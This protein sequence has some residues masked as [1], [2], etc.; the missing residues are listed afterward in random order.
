MFRSIMAQ[1]LPLTSAMLFHIW[2]SIFDEC[3][4]RLMHT[5]LEV[6]KNNIQYLDFVF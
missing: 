3:E 2:Y 4:V 5:A 6:H 1:H